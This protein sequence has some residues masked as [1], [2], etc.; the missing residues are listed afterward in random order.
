MKSDFKK[1]IQKDKIF[2]STV[3]KEDSLDFP[4]VSFCPIDSFKKS[5]DTD[6]WNEIYKSF[7]LTLKTKEEWQKLWNSATFSLEEVVSSV[8][9]SKSLYGGSVFLNLTEKVRWVLR[10]E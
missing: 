6:F 2:T 9:F 3:V 7:D 5:N 10:N 8:S 1:F 4:T